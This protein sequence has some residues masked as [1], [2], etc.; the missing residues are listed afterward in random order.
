MSDCTCYPN[1][2][3]RMGTRYMQRLYKLH[4]DRMDSLREL[5]DRKLFPHLATPTCSIEKRQVVSRALQLAGKQVMY[6][7]SPA[8]TRSGIENIMR[9]VAESVAC[10]DCKEAVNDHIKEI[11]TQWMILNRTI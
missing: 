1:P 11:S 10:E 6:D 2:V 4:G 7:A 3:D 9:G 5:L 8:M